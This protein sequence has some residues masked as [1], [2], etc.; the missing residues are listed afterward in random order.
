MDNISDIFRDIRDIEEA[1]L[2]PETYAELVD[3]YS[4]K[5]DAYID[6]KKENEVYNWEER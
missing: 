2:G 5:M 6:E 3:R 1:I 4:M